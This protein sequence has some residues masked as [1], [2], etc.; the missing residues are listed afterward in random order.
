LPREL[1]DP[2]LQLPRPLPARLLVV[3]APHILNLGAYEAARAGG[4]AAAATVVT[5]TAAAR[6]GPAGG[7]QGVALNGGLV[8]VLGKLLKVE[9]L[10][11]AGLE[12]GLEGLAVGL[13]VPQAAKVVLVGDVPKPLK[14]GA[15]VL[16][17]V[18]E[19]PEGG[20]DA[21]LEADE[22][23]KLLRQVPKVRLEVRLAAD[24]AGHHL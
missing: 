9:L 14:P 11:L 20:L 18:G 23:L 7:L 16:D 3:H 1:L 2:E 12:K 6:A 17:A 19:G 5:R 8:E 13:H 15:A 24:N 22:A 10:L 4:Q 21:R